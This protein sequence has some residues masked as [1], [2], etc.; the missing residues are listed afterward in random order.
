MKA[1]IFVPV[2]IVYDGVGLLAD[3]LPIHRFAFCDM[4]MAREY[5]GRCSQL[6]RGCST[7]YLAVGSRI[8]QDKQKVITI[9][10]TFLP[11]WMDASHRG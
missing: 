7:V 3:P 1:I 2:H 6:A 8:K 5:G 10:D 4:N 9:I 11:H